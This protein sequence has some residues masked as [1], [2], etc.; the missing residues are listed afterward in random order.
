M[1]S[2]H[3]TSAPRSLGTPPVAAGAVARHR[4]LVSSLEVAAGCC[5]G[6]AGA[7]HIRPIVCCPRSLVS[8]GVVL[9]PQEGASIWKGL[10][11][12]LGVQDA[13]LE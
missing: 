11:E 9:G 12:G 13:E 4:Q 2:T 7:G 10:S 5:G 6:G 8:G 3:T 1:M